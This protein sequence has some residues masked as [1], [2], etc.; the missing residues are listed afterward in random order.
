VFLALLHLVLSLTLAAQDPPSR[1]TVSAAGAGVAP[2]ALAA[3][4]SEVRP[5]L[6]VLR[7]AFPD[8]FDA[9]IRVVVHESG[10][11]LPPPLAALHHEGSPGFALL[12]R[13][14]VHLLLRETAQNGRGLRTV[15]Q[16]EFVHSLLDRRCARHGQLLPRWLHEGLAQHLA[17]DTYLGVSE[18]MIVWRIAAANLLPWADLERSFPSERRLLEVAYAQS[19]SFVSWLVRDYGLD[20]VLRMADSVDR[21]TS[22][23]LAMVLATGRSTAA[24]QDAWRQHV[25][26]GSGAPWRSALEHWFSLS[27]VLALPLLALALRRRLRVDRAARE[28]LELAEQ[29]ERERA[30]AAALAEAAALDARDEAAPGG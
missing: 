13:G 12:G 24:L 23:D 4:R 8:A 15:M 29:E 21:E 25:L 19:Y 14:E 20:A 5:A 16:H 10:A 3:V 2:E 6:A 27:M 11:D 1:V 30:R 18:A 7:G 9:P 22:F 17:G 26:H 28:R